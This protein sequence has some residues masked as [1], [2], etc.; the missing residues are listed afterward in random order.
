MVDASP[1]LFPP[2]Q[3]PKI[4]ALSFNESSPERYDWKAWNQSI[5][6]TGFPFFPGIGAPPIQSRTRNQ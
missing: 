6:E 2:H 1:T 3:Y 5:G 4:C